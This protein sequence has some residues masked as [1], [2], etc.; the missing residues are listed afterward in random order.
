M[1]SLPEEGS[2]YGQRLIPHLIDDIAHNNGSRTFCSL[3]KSS[4]I[5]DGFQ[6]ISYAAFAN[7]IN[8]LAWWIEE[9][10]GKSFT[11]ET[12]S[13][14]GPPDLRYI[15]LTI[16]AQK[17]G[18]KALFLSPRNSVEANL[19]LLDAADCRLFITASKCPPTFEALFKQRD[20]KR[21]I[22]PEL[23]D[24][25]AKDQVKHYPFVK[26][27]AEAQQDPFIVLHTSGSTGL[28][29]LVVATHGSFTASDTFQ[30]MPLLG[31]PPTMVE[32]LKDKRVFL[33]LPPFHSA[34]V[35]NMLA[36]PTYFGMIPVLPPAAPLTAD[37]VNMIHVYG[38]V[39]A[40]IMAPTIIEELVKIPDHLENLKLVD[41]V[42]YGGGQLSKEAG[43]LAVQKTGILSLMGSTETMLLPSHVPDKDEWQYYSFSPCLGAEFRHRWEDLYEMIIVRQP[44]WESSQ[45]IF[46]TFPDLQEYS[47]K[48]LY[49]PHPTK[50]GLWLYKGRSDDVIVFS[51]GEKINPITMEGIIGMHPDISSVL[52]MGQ[53]HFQSA[54]LVEAKKPSKSLDEK[55]QLLDK[56]WPLVE[57][58]NK[59]CPAHGRIS[60]EF[61]LF[62]TPE[63]PMLRAGK[64]TV[65]RMSTVKLYEPEL[66][67]LYA[68][69][70]SVPAQVSSTSL[71]LSS[72]ESLRGTLRYILAVQLESDRFTN[73]DDLFAFGL[74]SL[75]V[76]NLVRHIKTSL[77]KAGSDYSQIHQRLIYSN[78]TINQI[79]YAVMAAKGKSMYAGAP[80]TEQTRQQKMQS[81]FEQYSKDLPISARSPTALNPTATKSVILTGSTG[82]IGSY[83]LDVLLSDP[84][85]AHIYCFNRPHST[86]ATSRQS[87]INAANG[88]TT[89]FPR[90]KVTFLPVDLSIPYFGLSRSTY[91]TL[92]HNVTHIIHNAWSV[93]FNLSLQSFQPHIHGVRNFINFSTNSAHNASIFFISTIGTAME[94]PTAH[95]GNMPEKIVDDW[96][97]PQPMGYAESKYVSERLLDEASRVSGVPTAICRVGQVAGPT[98]GKGSWREGEWFPS[99]IRSSFELGILPSDLGPMEMVDWVP[100]DLLAKSLTE[101]FLQRP[102]NTS[103]P[104]SQVYHL[105]NPTQTTY[106]AF[107]ATIASHFPHP[108]KLVSLSEWLAAVEREQDLQK[109]PAGKLIDFY[110]GM[111]EVGEKGK[112]MVVL[113]TART[114]E[115]SE[116]LRGMEGVKGDWM[117]GWMRGWGL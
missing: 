55:E 3:V 83:L 8:R 52:V 109:N 70:Q 57:R 11:F 78:P 75:K 113:D 16:A 20:M 76:A 58:A 38:R 4:N 84:A 71:D 43:D 108:P 37:M 105:V 100:V 41:H 46:Y 80:G 25:I 93:N 66:D 19:S 31:Y 106:S 95:R 115:R 1:G 62:T 89:A 64:G 107:Q 98:N 101:L 117:E 82:S 92:L 17:T 79:T 77:E 47:M 94:W 6:D 13:Y 72:E 18:Y 9:N 90:T 35:F 51:T 81:I 12:V 63:K 48:D 39:K 99:L 73:D 27:F 49:S 15:I 96:S 29:K 21:H 103:Q 24:V 102:H 114:K 14:I 5:P 40:S 53:G 36:M 110:K 85:I 45:A 34:G 69:P 97:L 7:S 88:L 104:S 65:Q 112:K 2:V 28:P 61:V 111:V 23:H 87:Q 67:D 44:K 56:I 116:V 42:L 33:G 74:D 68:A 86:P 60:K 54:L 10:V 30:Q 22:M 59:D 26:T 32:P 50:P 91:K